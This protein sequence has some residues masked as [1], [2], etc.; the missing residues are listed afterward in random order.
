MAKSLPSRPNLD[1]LRRQAKALLAAFETGDENAVDTF[2]QYLPAAGKMTP[3]KIR[4]AKFRLADA[5]SAIARKTAFA[6]WPQL[7][8]HVEQLR[9]L[10]GTWEFDSLEVDGQSMPSS[11]LTSSRILIDGDCFRSEMSGTTYEGV[12]NIDVEKDPHH[13]DIE[14]VSGPEAGNWNF[15]IF[16]LDGDQLKICLNMVGKNRPS[17]FQTAAGSYQAL[18][19]LRRA[20]VARPPTV[21]GGTRQP[22]PQP[23]PPESIDVQF[24]HVD[25]PTLARLQGL[26]TSVRLVQDG[27]D[28]PNDFL[29]TGQRLATKNEI[30]VT[31]AGQ[32]M[33]HALV[34]IHEDT[35]P[36]QVDYCLLSGPA[37]G[38]IQ[39]GIMKWIGTDACFCMTSPRQPR[40]TDFNCPPGS[41]QSL[42]QWRPKKK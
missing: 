26:W 16:Y 22:R 21:T 35:D 17:A 14:F 1:H 27:K 20:S 9:A 8:H 41:G 3:S 15:G 29:K 23:I 40:P 42:S 18:E 30:K 24:A 4:E 6:N 38:V 32:T 2:H 31:F 7:A 19:F 12:F 36:I 37:K 10:E 11:M 5:Q 33:L 28:L 39:L 25:S 34:R 13:I